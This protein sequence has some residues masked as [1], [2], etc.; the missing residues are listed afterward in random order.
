MNNMESYWLSSTQTIITTKAR[1]LIG[2]QYRFLPRPSKVINTATIA[3]INN[4]LPAILHHAL[5]FKAL[6]IESIDESTAG[7]SE[8]IT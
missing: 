7:V 4:T 8:G 6:N 2:P 3:Q 1:K 5:V